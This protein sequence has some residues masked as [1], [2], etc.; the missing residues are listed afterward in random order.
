MVSDAAAYPVRFDVARQDTQSRLTNF[1]LGIGTFIRVILLVPHLV[2]LYFFQI[3]ASIVYFIATFAILFTG[4]Y[5]RGLFTFFV[6]YTRWAANVYAYYGSLYDKYPPFSMDPVD[7][8]PLTLSVDYPETLSRW[9]NFPL[10]IGLFIK[11]ILTIPHLVILAFL[12]LAGFVVVFIAHFAILFTGSFPE[13]MH[14]FVVGVGRWYIRV[15][16]YQYGLTDKYP[17]FSTN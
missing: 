2:I 6:G 15:N 11:L 4:K 17:P 12:L 5:P 13:G 16:A 8:F 1:P 10:F 7:G 9:L 3:A 14:R